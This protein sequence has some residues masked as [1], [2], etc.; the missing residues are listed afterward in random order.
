MVV[1]VRAEELHAEAGQLLFERLVEADP[2]QEKAVHEL[3]ALRAQ[4]VGVG[5]QRGVEPGRR[6]EDAR[7]EAERARGVRRAAATSWIDSRRSPPSKH[8]LWRRGPGRNRDDDALARGGH[9]RG[10]RDQLRRTLDNGNLL[11]RFRHGRSRLGHRLIAARGPAAQDVSRNLREDPAVV[12]RHRDPPL[13]ADRRHESGPDQHGDH[14][15]DGWSNTLSEPGQAARSLGICHEHLLRPP[16][17]FEWLRTLVARG[18]ATGLPAPHTTV[19]S[20]W[21]SAPR[22]W[23]RQKSRSTAAASSERALARGWEPERQ[24]KTKVCGRGPALEA[25][26]PRENGQRVLFAARVLLINQTTPGVENHPIALPCSPPLP[27]PLV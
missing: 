15:G 17:C 18:R 5:L 12:R 23:K 16:E 27:R 26:L 10:G 6:G 13:A 9:V 7:R 3:P 8:L 22:L 4:S 21:P 1:V 11:L 25:G 14:R 2:Q 19:L 24:D 20:G